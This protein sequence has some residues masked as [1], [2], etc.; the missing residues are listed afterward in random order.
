MDNFEAVDLGDMEDQD[1]SASSEANKLGISHSPLHLGGSGPIK[2]PE[3]EETPPSE[4]NP[5][6]EEEEKEV[7]REPSGTAVTISSGRITGVRTF[8]TKLH[9]GAIVFLDDQITDWLKKNPG[10]TIKRTNVTT[11]MIQ[12]KKTEP[13]LII[14]VWY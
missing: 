1:G 10:I 13:N 11:G 6:E 14:I 4:P 2:E 7:L 12:G 5:V 8:F 9:V 3:V